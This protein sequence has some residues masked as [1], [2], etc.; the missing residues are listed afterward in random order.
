MHRWD[1]MQC[2][3]G[4]AMDAELGR[5]RGHP[6]FI[7]TPHRGAPETSRVVLPFLRAAVQTS[8]CGLSGGNRQLSAHFRFYPTKLSQSVLSLLFSLNKEAQG[9]APKPHTNGSDLL[10]KNEG[11]PSQHKGG[12]REVAA[13]AVGLA[14]SQPPGHRRP[15]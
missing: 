1:S 11:H 10:S 14:A 15:F 3:T 2:S 13:I 8:A 12:S 5:S 4:D 7:S 6:L 9:L